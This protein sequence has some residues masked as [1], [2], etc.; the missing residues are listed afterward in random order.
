MKKLILIAV[1]TA[2]FSTSSFAV[3]N[4]A[5]EDLDNCRYRNGLVIPEKTCAEFRE[6][7]ARE[8]A[9]Q[10]R[11]SELMEQS[12]IER[13]KSAAED[14]KRQAAI[15][16]NRQKRIAEEARR[17]EENKRH[18]EKED[19]EDAEMEAALKRKCGKDYMN[20]RIGMTLA[21]AQLCIGDLTL[22]S[23]INRKDGVISTYSD[24]YTYINVMSD[25]IV[26]WHKF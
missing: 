5:D 2:G 1:C 21:R 24:G 11:Q 22:E 7:V 14:E 25:R 16:E 19:R 23:Q 20:P 4:P 13:E 12:R 9:A 15:D 3:W 26:S 17:D 18:Q 6:E 10:K 8:K